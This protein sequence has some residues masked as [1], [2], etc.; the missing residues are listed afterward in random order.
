VNRCCRDEGESIFTQSP[1]QPCCRDVHH[2]GSPPNC[3]SAL[4]VV[5]STEFIFD[6]TALSDDVLFLGGI[7]YYVPHGDNEGCT[8][9]SFSYNDKMKH[10]ALLFN[11]VMF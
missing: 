4:C 10:C 2:I 3:L 5:C 6:L 1:G 11:P 9:T 7:G 8:E